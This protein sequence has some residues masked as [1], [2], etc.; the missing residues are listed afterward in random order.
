MFSLRRICC[1]NRTVISWWRRT[2]DE[3]VKKEEIFARRNFFA[4]SIFANWQ[5]SYLKKKRKR[6]KNATTHKQW[7]IIAHKFLYYHPLIFGIVLRMLFRVL[8]SNEGM[9]RY[10]YSLRRWLFGPIINVFFRSVYHKAVRR[11]KFSQL[12]P[13]LV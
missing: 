8:I 10:E 7:S 13:Q 9:L 11:R 4:E 1:T 6:E 3:K 5:I 2:D 12:F